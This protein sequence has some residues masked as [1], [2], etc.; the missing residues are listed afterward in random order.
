MRLRALAVAALGGILMMTTNQA[1][2]T[3][4]ATESGECVQLR[5]RFIPQIVH[6]G[7][8]VVFKGKATNCSS[9][10]ETIKIKGHISGPCGV[11]LRRSRNVTLLPAETKV[12]KASF[13]A[14]PCPGTYRGVAKAYS[15]DRV[16]LDRVGAKLIVSL[17]A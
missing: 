3:P 16:L 12:F 15:L 7:D 9:Q 10:V 14:P 8:T 1:V 2:A 17:T 5:A 6:P 4:A 13:T 11:D